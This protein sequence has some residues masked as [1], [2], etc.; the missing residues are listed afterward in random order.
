VSQHLH[1][2]AQRKVWR[3]GARGGKYGE[4]QRDVQTPCGSSARETGHAGGARSC[5]PDE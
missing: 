4:E 3:R 1:T 5:I 2:L